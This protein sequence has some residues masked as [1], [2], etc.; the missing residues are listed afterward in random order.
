MSCVCITPGSLISC[1]TLTTTPLASNRKLGHVLLV[2]RTRLSPMVSSL[3]PWTWKLDIG[4]PA[5]GIFGARNDKEDPGAAQDLAIADKSNHIPPTD[6]GATLLPRPIAS[7]VTL[8]AQS[9]SLSLRV[10]TYFG[11]AAIDSARVTTL[12][13]LELS[14]AV[15]QGILTRAGRDVADRSD[16]GYGQ[17]EAESLLERSVSIAYHSKWHS[18]RYLC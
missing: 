13:G 18:L 3:Y 14:R 2:A 9:T 12:T 17:A 15:V 8:F 1:D 7:L 5:W 16:G 11:G 6:A 10:G 4:G